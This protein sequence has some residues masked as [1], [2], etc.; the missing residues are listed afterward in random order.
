MADEAHV[1]IMARLD[2]EQGLR[3]STTRLKSKLLIHS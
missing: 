2:T 3:V 1:A